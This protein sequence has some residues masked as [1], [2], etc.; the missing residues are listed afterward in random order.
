MNIEKRKIA[1]RI[2]LLIFDNN[3]DLASTF[4][5]FQEY[6]ESPEFKGKIFTLE[7]Y[8]EWYIRNSKKG[9]ETG[10]F[11]YY[12]DWGGFNIPSYVLDSFYEGKFNPLSEKEKLLL[13]QFK[14]KS[15]PFYILGVNR[16]KPNVEEYIE[17]EANHGLFYIDENYKNKVLETLEKF[18]ISEIEQEL[19]SN[20][21]NKNS[22]KDEVHSHIIDKE[23]I[24]EASLPQDLQKQLRE[25]NSRYLFKH[26]VRY[27]IIKKK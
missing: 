6:Y 16:K 23:W 22:L 21:Y 10:E 17:H 7:E 20:G 27:P 25:I 14:E 2:H 1:D 4:L 24:F 12:S 18:N 8:K 26:K 13:E 15:H 11:T 9:R 19:L 3:F 5:R